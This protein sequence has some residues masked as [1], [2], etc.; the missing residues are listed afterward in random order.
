[1][2]CFKLLGPRIASRTFDRQTTELKV[3]AEVLNRFSQIGSPTTIVSAVLV[4]IDEI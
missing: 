4:K 2:H 1:M 3:R